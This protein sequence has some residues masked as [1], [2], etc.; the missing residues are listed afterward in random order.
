MTKPSPALLPG[1]LSVMTVSACSYVPHQV[2]PDPE[3]A[4]MAPIPVEVPPATG[5]IYPVEPQWVVPVSLFEDVKARRVGDTLTIV[6][7]ER[8]DASKSASLNT[9]KDTDF[10]MPDPTVFG[11]NIDPQGHSILE[12]IIDWEREFDGEGDARQSNRM[13]GRITAVVYQVLPN[14]NLMVRGEK[15]LRI[16]EESEY[17]RITGIVRPTDILPDNT[18]PSHMVADAEIAYGGA[19]PVNET[20]QMGWMARFFN[21]GLWPF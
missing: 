21:S 1:L 17:V 7:Q 6:L 12:N 19:G 2:Q 13:D 14:G 18:V 15:I 3:Y 10:E 8:T 20:N 11:R 4:A 16:N 9:Q 5:S